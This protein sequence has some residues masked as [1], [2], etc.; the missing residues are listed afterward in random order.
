MILLCWYKRYSI[1]LISLLNLYELFPAFICANNTGSL[2]NSL[3]GVNILNPF[4][5]FTSCSSPSS[6]GIGCTWVDSSLSVNSSFSNHEPKLYVLRNKLSEP[7]LRF[8]AYYCIFSSCV[9]HICFFF[10]FIYSFCV[11]R[12]LNFFK[13]FKNLA[14][15]IVWFERKSIKFLLLQ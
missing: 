9:I 3:F 6:G 13:S 15:K 10:F 2:V 14:K 8:L 12:L 11:F 7:Y 5:P 4:P 1:W